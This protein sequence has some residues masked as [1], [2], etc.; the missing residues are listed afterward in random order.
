VDSFFRTGDEGTY[1]GG[2]AESLLPVAL[3]GVFLSAGEDATGPSPELLLRRRQW[4]RVVTSV[5]A[6][7]GAACLVLFSFQV[8][9]RQGEKQVRSDG[10]SLAAVTARTVELRPV[11]VEPPPR[12]PELDAVPPI[13]PEAAPPLAAPTPPKPARPSGEGAPR[14]RMARAVEASSTPTAASAL[15]MQ[16]HGSRTSGS[17][18]TVTTDAAAPPRAHGAPPTA[19]FP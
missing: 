10:G 15:G 8:G 12:A 11:V 13:V 14:P 2:P 4:Q 7:L 6:T 18:T 16:S 1:A 9:K 5:V 19:Y 17:L 3:E